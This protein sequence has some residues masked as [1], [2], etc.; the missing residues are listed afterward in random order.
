M[1]ETHGNMMDTERRIQEAQQK[2]AETHAE[3]MTAQKNIQEN[4]ADINEKI[5]L[6]E[7]KDEMLE[8]RRGK[9]VIAFRAHKV[10]DKS[11]ADN[12]VF[13][14]TKVVLN[15]GNGYS[16]TNGY[17]TAPISG[18]YF[19]NSQLCGMENRYI[20]YAIV[21]QGDTRSSGLFMPYKLGTCTSFSGAVRMRIGERAWVT[22][23]SNGSP[24]S[25]LIYEDS[26]EWNYFSG[27]LIR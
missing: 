17:F 27:F 9:D 20:A 2:M 6:L 12:Q 5:K 23:N 10:A 16:S 1:R 11:V 13:V 14:F 7:Q 24:S 19:F 26:R 22:I 15:E 4:L 25:D 18:I 21:S 3:I 8:A